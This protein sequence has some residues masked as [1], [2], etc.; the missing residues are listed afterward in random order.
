MEPL[1]RLL[2][3]SPS[4]VSERNKR[5]KIKVIFLAAHKVIML[6]LSL[7]LF[8]LYCGVDWGTS[9]NSGA[10]LSSRNITEPRM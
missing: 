10:V 1:L 2:A 3:L 8:A 5:S 7:L 6:D 9:H 4:D